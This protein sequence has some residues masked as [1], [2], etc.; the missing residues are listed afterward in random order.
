MRWQD[1]R[2]KTFR[3]KWRSGEG[4]GGIN[5]NNK[6]FLKNT[7]LFFIFIYNVTLYLELIKYRTPDKR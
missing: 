5:K 4:A 7:I 6:N 3:Y 1:P 2:R